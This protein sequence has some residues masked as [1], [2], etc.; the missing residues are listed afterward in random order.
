MKSENLSP[1][2]FNYLINHE[3]GLLGIAETSG[4]M[5]DLLLRENNDISAKEAIDLFCYEVKKKIGAYT[6][7]LGGID[8]LIFSGGIGENAPA[9]RQRICENLSFLGI[10]LDS[11]R[12]QENNGLISIDTSKVAVRIIPTDEAWMM[13]QIVNQMIRDGKITLSEKI[14]S[15]E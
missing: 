6:A 1:D 2:Q 11:K 3:S 9:I 5:A 14:Y 13:A 7:V 12:N 15:Y 4:D 10:E 8:T